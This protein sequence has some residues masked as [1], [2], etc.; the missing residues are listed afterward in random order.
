MLC[1][2]EDAT[3]RKGFCSASWLLSHIRIYV[4]VLVPA[5]LTEAGCKPQCTPSIN[6]G[7]TGE[8]SLLHRCWGFHSRILT[9]MLL[10]TE[11]SPQLPLSLLSLIII[12]MDYLPM[13]V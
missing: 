3:K 12:I 6:A 10:P 13:D 1:S 9:H 11:P 2:L 4:A 5:F 7:V 8:H